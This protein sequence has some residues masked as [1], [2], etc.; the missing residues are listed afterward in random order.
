MAI[1]FVLLLAS[2]LAFFTPQEAQAAPTVVTEEGCRPALERQAQSRSRLGAT[3]GL[4][5]PQQ[6]TAPITTETLASELS[7][8]ISSGRLPESSLIIIYTMDNRRRLNICVVGNEGVVLTS[9]QPVSSYRLSTAIE[10]LRWAYGVRELQFARAA[11]RS[12]QAEPELDRVPPEIYQSEEALSE[13]LFP[14]EVADAIENAAHLIVIPTG[15]IGT[16]P[17]Y[18]LVPTGSDY[19]L[20]ERT[21]ITIA[22]SVAEFT[23]Q[24]PS[25][26]PRVAFDAPLVIGDPVLP[27]SEDWIVP[28]LPGAREEAREVARKLSTRALLGGMATL[29]KIVGEA[30]RSSLIYVAA[31]GSSDPSNPL[32]GGLLMLSAPTLEGGFWTARMIQNESFDGLELSVLSACQTGL[33]QVHEGGM[34]GLARAFQIAGSR[35]VVM[36]LWNVD[37][38]ATKALMSHFFEFSRREPPSEALRLA[39]LELRKSEPDPVLWASFLAFGSAR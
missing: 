21:S 38:A 4:R 33:G 30:N 9:T 34:I 14:A 32:D 11:R 23:D 16:V 12:N 25:W 10:D 15:P 29:P 3:R 37:D 7:N 13:Y 27:A 18:S 31:H 5:Q 19:E 22:P 20:V 24:G 39:M 36:S 35:R 28:A 17:F 8:D 26:Q 1:R 6:E 2:V